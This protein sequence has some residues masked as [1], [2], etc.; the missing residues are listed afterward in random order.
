MAPRLLLDV[1]LGRLASYLRM[2]GYDTVYALDRNIEAD[3]ELLALAREEDRRLLTRDVLLAAQSHASI[4]IQERDVHEQLRELEA[5]GLTLELAEPAYCGRCNGSLEPSTSDSR[6]E[7]VPDE[8][9]ALWR[10]RDCGQFFWKGSHWDRVEQT[11]E[12]L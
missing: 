9:T 1:M 7:Y 3:D 6:P 4:L 8:V 12:S 2:C 5:T 11:L 10:C